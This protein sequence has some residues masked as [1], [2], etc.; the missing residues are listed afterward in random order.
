[1]PC[2]RTST[3]PSSKPPA[4]SPAG[5][6]ISDWTGTGSQGAVFQTMKMYLQRPGL[7][8]YRGLPHV[9]PVLRLEVPS[10]D[11]NFLGT[12]AWWAPLGLG[13]NAPDAY[14]NCVA[15]LHVP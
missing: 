7:V 6:R 9:V 10:P 1:M 8:T 2:L 5:L 14:L 11:R 3:P 12:P 15:E 13:N 4:E